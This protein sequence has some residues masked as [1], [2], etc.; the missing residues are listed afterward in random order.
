MFGPDLLLFLRHVTLFLH[1][2]AGIA[3][4]KLDAFVDWDVVLDP[5]SLASQYHVSQRLLRGIEIERFKPI[6]LPDAWIDLVLPPYEFDIVHM[7]KTIDICLVTG[8]RLTR[9]AVALAGDDDAIVVAEYMT[10][11]WKRSPIMMMTLTSTRATGISFATL[12]FNQYLIAKPVWLDKTGSPDIGFDQ[13]RIL[14]LDRER[15]NKV[16]DDFVSGK[17]MNRMKL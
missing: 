7:E 4:T 8:T 17:F 2:M 5:G 16:F 14:W 1:F 6:P 12:E 13:G 10:S 9:Q 3:V 11:K 15:L